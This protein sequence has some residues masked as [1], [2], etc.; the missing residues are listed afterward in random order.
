MIDLGPVQLQVAE[1]CSGIRYLF[2]L[3]ALALLGCLSVSRNACVKRLLLVISALPVSI[4]I[5]GL[6]RQVGVLVEVLWA[7]SGRGIPHFLKAGYCSSPPLGLLPRNVDLIEGSSSAWV[8][9]ALRQF[10][11]DIAPESAESVTITPGMPPRTSPDSPMSGN[12]LIL[13]ITLCSHPS[14]DG[15]IVPDRSAFVDFSMR[16]RGVA[17]THSQW[18][19]QLISAL[20]FDYF[21]WPIMRHRETSHALHGLPLAAKG[22]IRISPQSC[23][24]GGGWEILRQK[25]ICRW[26]DSPNRSM[27]VLNQ[28]IT[29]QLVVLVL[30]A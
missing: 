15:R 11:W 1:A 28:K 7:T 16:I 20:R 4:F 10:S 13:P 8:N 17:E 26:A 18:R 24:P 2:P 5:N 27:R 29:K 21:C 22:P 19:P 9:D 14:G 30:A 6:H 3:T 23:I 25:W 12:G